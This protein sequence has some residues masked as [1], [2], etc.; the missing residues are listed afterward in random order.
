MDKYQFHL[1]YSGFN[2]NTASFTFTGSVFQPRPEQIMVV[3]NKEKDNCSITKIEFIGKSDFKVFVKDIDREYIMQ[4]VKFRFH[5]LFSTNDGKV[6]K[7]ILNYDKISEL[8]Y[9]KEV[10]I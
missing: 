6:Y 4:K 1:C 5:I 10:E 7:Q 3:A 2:L 9:P 8:S